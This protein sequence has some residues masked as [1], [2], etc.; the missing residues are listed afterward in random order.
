MQFAASMWIRDGVLVNRMHINPTAFAVC[1][2]LFAPSEET[3]QLEQ[4]INFG[5]EKSG[6]SCREKMELFNEERG[7]TLERIDEAVEAYNQ[8]ATAAAATCDYFDGAPNLLRDLHQSGVKNFIT[9]AV[10]QPVLDRWLTTSQ[11]RLT[12]KFLERV[13]GSRD[14][15]RKGR[16]HFEHVSQIAGGE[17]IIYVADAPSEIREASKY[18]DEFNIVPV[19]FGYV[20]ESSNIFQAAYTIEL[21]ATDFAEDNGLEFG[22]PLSIFAE[23][24]KLPEAESIAQE[25]KAAGAKHVVTGSETEII[26]NLRDLVF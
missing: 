9:S 4:L 15:F 25:L 24:L 19:G 10:E 2:Q 21:V 17:P 3:P 8:I 26:Q 22:T 7:G 14:G 16:D 13:L 18:A 1:Y 5:F 20:I 11:G 6:I 12:G 23:L